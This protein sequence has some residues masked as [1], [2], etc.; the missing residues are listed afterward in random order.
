MTCTVRDGRLA[1]IVSTS[2]RP[3]WAVSICP[4]LM[5]KWG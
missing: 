3:G 4:T 1:G 2:T 5:A